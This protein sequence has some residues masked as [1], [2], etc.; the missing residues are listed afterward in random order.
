MFCHGHIEISLL[1]WP[2][3]NSEVVPSSSEAHA[4]IYCQVNDSKLLATLRLLEQSSPGAG[5][6]V[7]QILS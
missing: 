1:L 4:V 2:A 7:L 3:V 6:P 5:N